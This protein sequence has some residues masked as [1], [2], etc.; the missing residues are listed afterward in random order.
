MRTRL[1]RLL[2]IAGA[3]A[4]F[5]AACT[6][7]SDDGDAGSSTTEAG[8]TVD[9]TQGGGVLDEVRARDSV[10]CGTR[11]A[12]PPFALLTPDGEHVGFDNDFCR[13]IAAAV[14]GD[15][16]KV[17]FV[18]L[19]TAARFTALQAGE[20]DVL[21]RNTTW[22]AGRDGTEGATFLQPNFYDGQG[23]MVLTGSGF[24]TISDMDGSV[25]CSA[26]GTTSEGNIAN[27][28]IRL[29]IEGEVLSF[30]DTDLLQE[31]FQAGRCDGWTSDVGQLVG[32]RSLYPDGPEALTI[33]DG[34]FS[35]EPLGPVVLDG[36]PE[37]AQ[38]VNWAVFAVIQAEEWG[39]TSANVDT[40]L[41]STDP[42][43]LRFLGVE[44][45]GATFDPG[46]G[47]P[48]DYAYQVISQ[49]G[50]YGE[51]Y[52]EHITPLGLPRGNNALWFD[53]GM[54]YAPPYK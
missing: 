29:G 2:A 32:L 20:V 50:N 23:M 34:V 45:D 16:S 1:W 48:T 30:A 49:V 12:L 8:D 11:D 39:I 9:L 19:E 28:F 24:E 14:L 7:D 26:G 38:Q 15:A 22:T 36:Q 51:I 41:T 44:I 31:A 6:G 35:K 18:D 10:R 43:I 25:I 53:G 17:E 27:E 40:F 42:N 33:L 4:V 13:V 3:V 54:M 5:S 52:A 21:V 47:L 37:W 46:L